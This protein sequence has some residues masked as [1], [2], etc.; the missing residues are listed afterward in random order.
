MLSSR[1]LV[2]LSRNAFGYLVQAPLANFLSRH[3]PLRHLILDDIG[4]GPKAGTSSTDTAYQELLSEIYGVPIKLLTYEGTEED[5]V[6]RNN[7]SPKSVV[8]SA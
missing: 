5:S 7:S 1:S 3:V 6:P 8:V 4:L 2:N